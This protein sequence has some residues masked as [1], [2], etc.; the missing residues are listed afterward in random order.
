MLVY[1]YRNWFVTVKGKHARNAFNKKMLGIK[2][3]EIETA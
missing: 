3:E 2:R 1:G